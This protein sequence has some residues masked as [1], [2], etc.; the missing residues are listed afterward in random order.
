MGKTDKRTKF[1]GGIFFILLTP[2]LLV[3]LSWAPG[4]CQAD[5]MLKALRDSAVFSQAAPASAPNPAVHQPADPRVGPIKNRLGEIKSAAPSQK[6]QS[7]AASGQSAGP[8]NG[9]AAQLTK[10]LSE[11]ADIR[12]RSPTGAPRQIKV[13]AAARKN[14]DFL[15]KAA[16][17]PL[18]GP[19]RDKETARNFLR[20][21]R[22]NL[23]IQDPDTELS[24]SDY[25]TDA[26]N[27]RH[28]RFR[29]QY[30]GLPVW[31]AELNVHLDAAGNVDLMNGA[32]IPTPRRL[33][34]QPVWTAEQA[35]NQARGAVPSDRK[36]VV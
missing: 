4:L 23:R 20:S 21:R 10:K 17:G 33:V 25:R 19:A 24:L 3:L 22:S 6:S 11:V 1:A 26:L 2:I 16:A 27:R 18:T 32:F 31:P 5:D 28:L 13:K 35:V 34:I 29:Q 14:G 30:Q 15:E 12:F 9:A 7:P 8:R 36:S